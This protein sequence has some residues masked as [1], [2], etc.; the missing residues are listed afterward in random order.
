MFTILFV[1]VAPTDRL[2]FFKDKAGGYRP[3]VFE[4]W[5]GEFTH[6]KCPYV[7]DDVCGEWRFRQLDV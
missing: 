2:Y 5:S 4:A 7:G 6:K 3:F 1:V